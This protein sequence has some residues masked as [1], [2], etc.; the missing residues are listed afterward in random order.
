VCEACSRVC[1][2]HSTGKGGSKPNHVSAEIDAFD[3][4]PSRM[5]IE[6]LR[7]ALNELQLRCRVACGCL[8][9][10][11]FRSTISS[12]ALRNC[13][14]SAC[15]RGANNRLVVCRAA[16]CAAAK[17]DAPFAVSCTALARLS[18]SARRRRNHPRLTRRATKSAMLE[19]SV[20]VSSTRAFCVTPPPDCFTALSTSN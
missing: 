17:T 19:R 9:S 12:R 2:P 20:P 10:C 18:W 7:T 4:P 15:G 16:S 14:R 1:F 13:T 3:D 11:Y 8:G 5:Q 6:A